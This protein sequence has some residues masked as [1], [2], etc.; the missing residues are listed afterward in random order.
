MRPVSEVAGSMAIRYVDSAWP[1]PSGRSLGDSQLHDVGIVD[2]HVDAA[3]GL[4]G[5]IKQ[6]R[7]QRCVRHVGLD[8]DRLPAAVLIFVTISSAGTA[9]PV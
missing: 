9:L 4:L 6:R 2:P 7:Y 3:E 5:R 1:W 8:R